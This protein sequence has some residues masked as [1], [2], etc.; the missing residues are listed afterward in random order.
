MFLVLTTSIR[1]LTFHRFIVEGIDEDALFDPEALAVMASDGG[2]IQSTT[3]PPIE[4]DAQGLI[5][6]QHFSSSI[7]IFSSSTLLNLFGF[8]RMDRTLVIFSMH[9]RWRK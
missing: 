8:Q 7:K 6:S 5:Y 3:T 9:K 2:N 4:G 1:F